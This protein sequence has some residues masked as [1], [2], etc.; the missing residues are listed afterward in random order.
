MGTPNKERRLRLS[1][2]FKRTKP[3]RPV[4]ICFIFLPRICNN[5]VR[6]HRYKC[7]TVTRYK[8]KR[9]KDFSLPRKKKKGPKTSE[10]QIRDGR[11]VPFPRRRKTAEAPR[12]NPREALRFRLRQKYACS[13]LCCRVRSVCLCHSTLQAKYLRPVCR[14]STAW[15]LAA[16]SCSLCL[17]EFMT[18]PKNKKKKLRTLT[19]FADRRGVTRK[20]GG[21]P[22]RFFH[23][24]PARFLQI[25]ISLL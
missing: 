21:H 24:L 15:H 11:P 16:A 22:H 18:A 2:V 8:Y 10:P 7:R 3:I 25:F 6:F 19:R 13:S 9:I 1:V 4:C 14:F 12:P 5:S 17:P 23:G 20:A